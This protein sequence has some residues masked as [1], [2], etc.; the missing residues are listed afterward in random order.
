MYHHYS[1]LSRRQLGS[2]RLVTCVSRRRHSSVIRQRMSCIAGVMNEC[3]QLPA[4]VETEV[5]ISKQFTASSEFQKDDSSPPIM[6]LQFPP[7]ISNPKHD[8]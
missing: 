7:H 1:E 2:G 5:K 4:A 8:Y 6:F 3:I